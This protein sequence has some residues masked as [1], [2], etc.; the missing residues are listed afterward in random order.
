MAGTG[1]QFKP[2]CDSLSPV[3][4]RAASLGGLL[5]HHCGCKAPMP[6]LSLILWVSGEAELIYAS[7]VGAE[8][9]PER[10]S[11]P[12]CRKQSRAIIPGGPPDLGIHRVERVT[13][14]E[15]A[16]SA[17]ESV[18]NVCLRRMTCGHGRLQLAVRDH[19]APRLMAR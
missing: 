7:G 6:R 10:A 5:P 17:W 2:I 14:I 12:S 8:P 16:L 13:R 19:G 4:A 3:A 18:R 15:L 11:T 9:V 1:T